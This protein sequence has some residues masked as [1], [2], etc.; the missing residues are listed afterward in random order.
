LSFS[1]GLLA[2]F[3]PSMGAKRISPRVEYLLAGFVLLSQVPAWGGTLEDLE[4]LRDQCLYFAAGH[5]PADSNIVVLRHG[6][7]A[8]SPLSQPGEVDL[9]ASGFSLAALPAAV[10]NGVISSNAAFGIASEAARQ[11]RA[12]V[13]K[14]A[15]ASTPEQIRRYGYG[16]VL[17]HYPVWNTNSGEF[18]AQPG[19]ELSSIDTTLLMFGLLVSANYF[20]DPV[21]VDYEAACAGIRWR[22]WLDQS[23]PGH[24]NQFHMAYRAGTGFYAW[25]DWYT[26]EAMLLTLFA[27]MSDQHIDPIKVWRGWRRPFKTYTSPGPGSKS[28]TCCATYF[29]DPFTVVYG[30]AFLDLARLPRDIDGINW[31]EQGQLAYQASVEFFKKERGYLGDLSSGFSVCAPNGVMAPPHGAPEQPLQRSDATLYTVAGGLPYFGFFGDHNG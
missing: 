10:A 11:V 5:A 3:K 14:S 9:A 22:D 4:R 8:Q 13:T 29:G 20:G 2:K 7:Y 12:M 24:Q 30:L 27:S 18:C 19:V 15:A 17:C 16:G 1:L 28:F 25:W 31:F 6:L 21:R 23:T 26:Q